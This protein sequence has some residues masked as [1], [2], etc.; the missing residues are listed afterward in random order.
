MSRCN[1]FYFHELHSS[2]I[3]STSDN[4]SLWI[5]LPFRFS[6]DHLFFFCEKNPVTSTVLDRSI[7]CHGNR[8][9]TF[10]SRFQ[11]TLLDTFILIP[12][13]L[14]N[15]N[16]EFFLPIILVSANGRK[17]RCPSLMRKLELIENDKKTGRA[18]LPL[19]RSVAFSD[20]RF[21]YSL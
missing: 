11:Y 6:P 3:S 19:V 15:G 12:S 8:V 7:S 14:S 2:P 1:G 20:A 17:L 16:A 18:T 13:F 5:P 9:I 21:Q 4:S 10:R